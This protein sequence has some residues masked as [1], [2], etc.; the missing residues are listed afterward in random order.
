M[1]LQVETDSL[2][3]ASSK[4]R[5]LCC[6]LYRY[7]HAFCVHVCTAACRMAFSPP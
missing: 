3:V 6:T 2:L 4:L 7:N 1:T 5:N